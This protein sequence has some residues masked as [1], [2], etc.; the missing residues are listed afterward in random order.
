MFKIVD[1]LSLGQQIKSII[2]SLQVTSLLINKVLI[3]L[4][5]IP[6]HFHLHSQKEK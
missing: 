1:N 4:T 3:N 6:K 5:G 2:A